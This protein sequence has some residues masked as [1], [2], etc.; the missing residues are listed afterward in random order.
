MTTQRRR[1]FDDDAFDSDLYDPS[2]YPKRVLRDGKGIRVPVFLT[3]GMPTIR[4]AAFDA[5]NH[6]PH[7][8]GLSDVA[9]YAA[10]ADARN[11]HLQDA[12]RAMGGGTGGAAKTTAPPADDPGESPRDAYIRRI[13]SWPPGS[14]SDPDGDDDAAAIEAQRARWAAPGATP[15]PGYGDAR[16]RKTNDAVAVADRDAA[17]AEYVARISDGWRR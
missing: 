11:G 1:R 8:A 12:W 5:R 10:F 14:V 9:A 2:Y 7:S 15:G 13:S 4:Q 3:D 6:Q 17:Y 16:P